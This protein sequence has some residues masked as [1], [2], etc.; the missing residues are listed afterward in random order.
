MTKEMDTDLSA[1]KRTDGELVR[2]AR[3]GNQA[4]FGN[5][6]ERYQTVIKSVALR[7]V[8]DEE[9]ARE[10]VQ[11]ALLQAFLSLD[12]LRDVESFKSWLYGIVMNICRGYLRTGSYSPL[13][14]ESLPDEELLTAKSLNPGAPDPQ[15][16]IEDHELHTMIQTAI[17]GL[18]PKLRQ[19]VLFYYYDHL[20]MQEIVSLLG[21]SIQAVKVRLHRARRQLGEFLLQSYPEIDLSLSPELR[22]KTMIKVHIADIFRKEGAEVVLL[23]DDAE[24]WVLPIWI[25][26]HEAASIAA[27]L[28]GFSTARPM[29]YNFIASLLDAIGADLTE[30]RIEALKEETFYGVAKLHSGNRVREIDARPSDILALAART[31]S[32]IFVGEEVMEQAGI[33]LGERDGKPLRLGDGIDA[34]IA[35]IQE[36]WRARSARQCA[37]VE[38]NPRQGYEEILQ[39]ILRNAE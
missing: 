17:E 6:I 34:L 19:V 27:G 8:S 36:S 25:G 7:M 13:H 16:A 38:E 12:R 33:D 11:E 28:R 20:S 9:S 31:G 29:T 1:D 22:R 5:L 30:A 2:L 18:S 23:L 32:P 4:A 39:Y 10:L 14:L 37:E 26:R 15:Q 24:R 21:I 35:E 3:A